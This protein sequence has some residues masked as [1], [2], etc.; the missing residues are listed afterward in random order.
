[1]FLNRHPPIGGEIGAVYGKVIPDPSTL[2][3][4][5]NPSPT[6]LSPMVMM[7]IVAP[8]TNPN[9]RTCHHHNAMITQLVELGSDR[10]SVTA[11]RS[12]TPRHALMILAEIADP[13][14][15]EEKS[16]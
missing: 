7:G 15:R 8:V 14:A 10:T 4:Q 12:L 16:S 11:V 2:Q 3:R 13:A 6:A 1:L 9:G 5:T